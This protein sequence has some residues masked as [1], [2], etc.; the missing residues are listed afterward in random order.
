M[1]GVTLTFGE[2][3]RRVGPPIRSGSES[4]SDWPRS[5]VAV[6]MTG[7]TVGGEVWH[8]IMIVLHFTGAMTGRARPCGG[9]AAGMTHGAVAIRA[10]MVSGESMIELCSAP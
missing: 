6:G 4:R 9:V 5:I 7:N 3:Q 1:T 8:F 10:A 2:A